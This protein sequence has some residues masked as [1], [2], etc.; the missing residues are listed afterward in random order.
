MEHPAL[1]PL[2]GYQWVLFLAAHSV[3]HTKQ[4]LELKAS[5]GFPLWATGYVA[6]PAETAESS[7]EG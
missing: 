6:D 7:S 2:D 1:G 3:R 4:I 5:A